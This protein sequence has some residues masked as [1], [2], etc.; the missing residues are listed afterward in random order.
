MAIGVMGLGAKVSLAQR[1]A[2]LG[3]FEGLTL[4]FFIT[5][6]HQGPIGRIE[7]EAHHVPE[8]FLKTEGPWRA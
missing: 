4:A 2:G 8:L 6:E 1:Q 7:L 3:A 5:A